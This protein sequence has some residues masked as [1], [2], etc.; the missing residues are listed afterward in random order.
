MESAPYRKDPQHCNFAVAA[1]SFFPILVFN[2]LVARSRAGL[3]GLDP[4]RGQRP[5]YS[6]PVALGA[7]LKQLVIEKLSSDQSFDLAVRDGKTGFTFFNVEGAPIR[8]RCHRP[9]A[10]HHR[11]KTPDFKRVC[12]RARPTGRRQRGSWKNFNRRGD[13]T[14]RDRPAR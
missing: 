11:G 6:L 8:L 13:A 7:S 5:G 12:Q 2:E 9:V 10:Q 14:D 4:S 3:D 1:N